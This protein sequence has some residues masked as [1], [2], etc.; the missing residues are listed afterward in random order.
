M[1]SPADLPDHIVA[2]TSAFEANAT[3]FGAP[4]TLAESADA[5]ALREALRSHQWNISAAARSLGVDR[6]TMH[7]RMRRLGVGLP[8]RA[9]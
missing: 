7:R 4:S 6:T 1:I 8:P 9:N 3:G 2:Q 5:A